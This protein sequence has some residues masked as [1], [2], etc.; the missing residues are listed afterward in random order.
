MWRAEVHG[1]VLILSRLIFRGPRKFL[2][3]TGFYM[4]DVLYLVLGIVSLLV[5][6]LYAMGLQRI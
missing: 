5:F 2:E 1:R 6:A 3:R 4:T